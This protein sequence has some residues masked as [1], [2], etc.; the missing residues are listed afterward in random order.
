[1]FTN[2]AKGYTSEFTIQ[3]FDGKYYGI[4]RGSYYHRV[5]PERI[6]PTREDALASLNPQI[7][8]DEISH[9]DDCDEA[10]DKDITNGM[11]IG[12]M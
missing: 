6:F 8:D 10:A 5:S 7:T 12:V 1:M 4:R 3:N 9:A 2:K 11:Q